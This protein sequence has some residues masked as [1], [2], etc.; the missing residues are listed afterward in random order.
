MGAGR[1][2]KQR[3]TNC[4]KQT[5]AAGGTSG[6][7][8]RVQ[9]AF[10]K[11]ARRVREKERK[12]TKHLLFDPEGKFEASSTSTWGRAEKAMLGRDRTFHPYITQGTLIQKEMKG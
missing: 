11:N 10:L 12:E 4:R 9:R 5:A 1:P 6:S 3:P 8:G 7:E 2:R